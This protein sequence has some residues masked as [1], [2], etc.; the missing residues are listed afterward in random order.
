MPSFDIFGL[1]KNAK[2]SGDSAAYSSNNEPPKKPTA[3]SRKFWLGLLVADGALVLACIGLLGARVLH[4]QA[5][6]VAVAA[7]APKP[8]ATPAPKEPAKATTPDAA[9]PEPATA[10]PQTA[11]KKTAQ[12][13]LP[14]A[15]NKP[16][17]SPGVHAKALPTRNAAPQ[18]QPAKPIKKVVKASTKPTKKKRTTKAVSFDYVNPDAKE[19]SLI[20]MFLVRGGGS[21]KMFRNSKGAW[22]TSVYLKTGT[23]YRYQFEVRGKDGRKFM[24]PRKTVDVF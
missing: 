19:V 10:Q 3:K 14:P 15:S 13:P 1:G 7:R 9:K 17:G 16:L 8:V 4:H 12:K 5:T 11:P 22:Q 23:T 6:P 21:K 2:P 18:G 24:T 20:G